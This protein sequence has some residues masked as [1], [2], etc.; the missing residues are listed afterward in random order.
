MA[1]TVPFPKKIA[2]G[3]VAHIGLIANCYDSSDIV[4]GFYPGSEAKFGD[5]WDGSWPDVE[6]HV[7]DSFGKMEQFQLLIAWTFQSDVLLSHLTTNAMLTS[8]G[9]IETYLPL[10][11][12]IIDNLEPRRIGL[13]EQLLTLLYNL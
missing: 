10:P 2:Q 3:H 5:N 8:T 11:S 12:R 13:L 6:H 4:Q 7:L 1:T 9:P